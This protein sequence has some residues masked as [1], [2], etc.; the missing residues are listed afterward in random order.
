MKR[1]RIHDQELYQKGD[2]NMST[3]VINGSTDHAGI[4]R[5]AVEDQCG[6]RLP[7]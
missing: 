2:V 4:A 1:K 7:M 3:V 6:T 5:I